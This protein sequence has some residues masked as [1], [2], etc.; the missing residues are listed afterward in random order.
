LNTHNRENLRQVVDRLV[1]AQGNEFVKELL[2][3]K[4]LRIGT[5]K[6]EFES[7]LHEA[8]QSG[9][10]TADDVEEWLAE[11]EGWGAHHAYIFRIDHAAATELLNNTEHFKVALRRARLLTVHSNPNR[12]A[13]P[14]SLIPTS[15]SAHDSTIEVVWHQ[16]S[17]TWVPAPERDY[18]LSE[19]DELFRFKAER[20]RSER[21]VA[22]LVARVDIDLAGIFI[23]IPLDDERHI[24]AISKSKQTA[25]LL[26]GDA[27][28]DYINIGRAQL[29]LD[30]PGAIPDRNVTVS[31]SRMR[32]QGAYVEFGAVNSQ[33]DF[34]DV[35]DVRDV[36]LAARDSLSGESGDF[37]FVIGEGTSRSRVVKVRLVANENRV[38]IRAQIASEDEWGILQRIANA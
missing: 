14:T 17:G 35:A 13:F 21:K 23:S 34:N 9:E 26:L 16:G 33:G 28:G 4:K 6:A 3:K 31:R 2:R 11:V 36:R 5:K 1:V 29:Q 15:A 10:L 32:S 7:S 37:N 20:N 24:A 38:Y 12:F 22:R 27:M 19:G 25:R 30:H 18:E 8:I